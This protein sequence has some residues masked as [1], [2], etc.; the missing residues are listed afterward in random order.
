MEDSIG[1]KIV[2]KFESC[3]NLIMEKVKQ[4]NLNKA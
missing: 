4:P 3:D 1:M 2:G